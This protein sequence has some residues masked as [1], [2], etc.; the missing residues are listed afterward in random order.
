MTGPLKDVTILDLSRDVPGAYACMLLG[1]MGASVVKVEPPAGSPERSRPAFRLWNRG[2]Q[3]LALD[4]AHAAGR[5]AFNR[6]VERAD[7]LVETFLP[8]EVRSMN[9]SHEALSQVNPRLIYCALPPFGDSGPLSDLPAD[10]GVVDA[11]AG[12]YGDQGGLDFSPIFIHLPISYYATG[13]MASFAISSALFVRET[14]G[15]GQKVEMP[16]YSGALAVEAHLL[17]TGNEALNVYKRKR[18]QLGSSPVYRLYQCQDGWLVV[19]CG[20][21]VLWDKLCVALE[22]EH[23]T[24]DERLLDAP[25]GIPIEYHQEVISMLEPIFR[26]KTVAHWLELLDAYGV[27]VARVLTRDEYYDH[28]QM[29]HNG[30]FTEVQDQV[31]GPTVQPGVFIEMSETPGSVRGAAPSLGQHTR[32]VLRDAGYPDDEIDELKALGVV[33]T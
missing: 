31:L 29:V 21:S 23:L 12:V 7:V 16:W 9:L 25:W 5:D 32:E 19:A 11:Y 20:N 6:L 17:M 13:M 27:P 22:L 28:P 3:S 24:A 18:N 33:E 10:A 4:Y 1:D 30:V 15:Q 14:T 26:T 2:K 8:K